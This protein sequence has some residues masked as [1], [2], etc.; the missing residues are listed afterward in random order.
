MNLNKLLIYLL[1]VALAFGQLQRFG[2]FYLHDLIVLGLIL[3]NFKFIRFSKPL[4]IFSSVCLL[5]LILNPLKLQLFELLNSALYL[6][7]FLSYAALLPIFKASKLNLKSILK[8][9]VLALA[10]FGLLQYFFL[11]DTRFL[12]A[13]NWDDH[14]FRA[15][16]TIFD[17]NYL[18]IMLVLGLIIFKFKLWPSLFLLITLFLTYSRSSYLALVVTALYL[19]LIKKKMVF[20]LLGFSA[21]CL[22]LVLL[23]RPGGDGVKLER[24]FSITQRLENYQ[25]GWQTWQRY[26]VFGIGFNTLKY[27]RQDFISHSA[28]GYDSSFIFVLVTTGAIGLLAYLNW[29]K[30]L[31]R[32]SLLVKLSLIALIIHACF[33]NTLF[34]PWALIWLW[35]VID[36]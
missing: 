7:R 5:S 11:P 25:S 4:I 13:S 6:L 15:L 26:P 34:Y 10:A 3:L 8:P 33:Q 1:F 16:G 23:P 20:F 22:V 14:Y 24:M 30:S 2:I 12:A 35:S 32:P 28:G 31:W 29:L 21:L 36:S 19:A 17:P 18:G 27:F 9:Y